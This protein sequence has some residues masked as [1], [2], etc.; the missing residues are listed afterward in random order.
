MNNANAK[1]IPVN[2][3][4]E[5]GKKEETKPIV[6]A[7]GPI[8]NPG[9][10]SGTVKDFDKWFAKY[11]YACSANKWN[12]NEKRNRIMTYLVGSA[13]D[14]YITY[15]RTNESKS[16][17]EMKKA[18]KTVFV[19]ADTR[20]NCFQ[21]IA[22]RRQKE[23]EKLFDYFYDKKNLCLSYNPE[24]EDDEIQGH[25][26]QGL[27][28]TLRAKAHLLSV[29]GI[30]NLLERLRVIQECCGK[31]K[32][33]Q[34]VDVSAVEYKKNRWNRF[35]RDKKFD[36]NTSRDVKF[37]VDSRSNDERRKFWKSNKF[38]VKNKETNNF[39]N[40]TVP[41]KKDKSQI[42][43][44]GCGKKGHIKKDCFKSKNY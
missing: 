34:V 28:D 14:W 41:F 30:D 3:I 19:G 18:M 10:Y 2:S 42:E 9:T 36:K 32:P 1:T 13:L 40:K 22:D 31:E 26:I 17:D 44:Y 20:A 15:Q 27:N 16:Y 4:G 38:E 11:E 7:T 8:V 35:G 39:A 24:M 5:E 21:Q 43:C 23:D 25:I 37:K 6:Y 12:E 29:K 33:I